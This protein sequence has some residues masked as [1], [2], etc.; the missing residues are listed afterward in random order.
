MT[1]LFE[2]GKAKL[3][4]VGAKAS[5]SNVEKSMSSND[6]LSSIINGSTDEKAAKTAKKAGIGAGLFTLLSQ[7]N[8]TMASTLK[9]LGGND[10]GELD[11]KNKETIAGQLNDISSGGGEDNK[12]KNHLQRK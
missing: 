10:K 5:S 1:S 8:H 3:K 2:T 11:E 12:K 7:M 4:D 6:K 9:L